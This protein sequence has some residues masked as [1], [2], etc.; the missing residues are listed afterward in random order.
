MTRHILQQR[1]KIDVTEPTEDNAPGTALAMQGGQDLCKR[2]LYSYVRIVERS[3]DPHSHG[4]LSRHDVAEELEARPVGPVQ[5]I[6]NHDH[7]VFGRGPRQEID[8]ASEEHIP[9]CFGI[10]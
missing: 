10:S 1:E 7:R 9:F 4:D 6:E 5:V 3:N 2:V 8:H